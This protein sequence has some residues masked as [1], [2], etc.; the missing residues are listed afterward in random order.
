MF[1]VMDSKKRKE[2]GGAEMAKIKKKIALE[3]DAAKC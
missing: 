1:K 3:E 2:K